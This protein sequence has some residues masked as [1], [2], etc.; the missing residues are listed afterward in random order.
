MTNDLI[1]QSKRG[2]FTLISGQFF[3]FLVQIAAIVIM[4][5]LLSADDYGLTA[6]VLSVVSIGEIFRDFGLSSAAIQAESLSQREK[7]NLFW[8]NTLIGLILS[9]VLFLSSWLIADFFHDARLIPISQVLAVVFVINGVA[10]QYKAGLNRDLKLKEITV[11]ESVA[12]FISTVAAIALA[13]YGI[14]YWAV[15]YQQV[16][17]YLLV[18][19]LFAFY[20]GW[21]PSLPCFKTNVTHFSKF[22][23]NMLGA[24]LLSQV[25][26]SADTF[27]IGKFFGTDVLGIYNRAQQI[28]L[29]SLNRINSPSTTLALPVLSRLKNDDIEYYKF[30]NYG[31]SVLL[32]AVSFTFSML[33]IN[34]KWI[35][36]V[37]LGAKWDS[38]VYIVQAL[39]VVA[40]IQVASYSHFWICL[41]KNLMGKRFLFS[42]YTLPVFVSFILIGAALGSLE[43]TLVGLGLSN[44]IL[45]L[46]SIVFLRKNGIATNEITHAPYVICF[47]YMTAILSLMAISHFMNVNI[48][49]KHIILNLLLISAV[50][51]MYVF[52]DAFRMSIKNII[53]L[54]AKAR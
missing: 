20:H 4:S 29:I 40:I 31:Q 45:W 33:A 34:A 36:L 39:C 27:I 22:G 16:I 46:C 13:A 50:V 37:V 17:N 44:L 14:G 2:V 43:T 32:Q 51:S 8:L 5:R 7:S 3:R 6:I 38:A 52:S 26:R 9:V 12:Q 54:K 47:F 48:V 25:I 24:Q 23:L 11:S 41:S 15:V 18:L 21:I 30:L 28:V 49:I 1:K 42:I 53:N 10:T 19:V 35:V